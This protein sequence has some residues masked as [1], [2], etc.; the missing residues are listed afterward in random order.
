M[1]VHLVPGA[2][3]LAAI[4]ASS[5]MNALFT[6]KFGVAVAKAFEEDRFD[7]GNAALAATA[8]LAGV[9]SLPSLGEI[10]EVLALKAA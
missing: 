5:A 4:G 3:T 2:G 6:Y 7:L 9:C 8:V 1:A 10:R